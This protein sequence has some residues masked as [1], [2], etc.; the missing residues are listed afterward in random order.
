MIIWKPVK[1][2][3]D[4]Y[5]VSNEGDVRLIASGKVLKHYVN[6]ANAS[7]VS[8]YRNGKQSNKTVGR[9]V[10]EAFVPNPDNLKCARHKD[11][12]PQNNKAS[13]LYWSNNKG[14]HWVA[15]KDLDTG[16]CYESMRACA[17]DL[18]VP[19]VTVFRCVYTDERYHGLRI[20]VKN[21][22]DRKYLTGKTFA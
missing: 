15:V 6:N 21:P 17:R 4:L 3:E 5:E 11:G 10:A 12:N 7:I 13:N 18:G 19:K 8:L 1:G 14:R 22:E 16:K 2:F 9:I 20:S